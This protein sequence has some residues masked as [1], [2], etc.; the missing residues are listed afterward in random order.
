MGMEFGEITRYIE[1]DIESQRL[2][3][4]ISARKELCFIEGV[5]A[6][7]LSVFINMLHQAEQGNTWVIFPTLEEA[8]NTISDL[9]ALGISHEFFPSTGKSLY[10]TVIDHTINTNEQLN[11]LHTLFKAKNDRQIIVTTVRAFISP[12]I[13]LRAL[14]DNSVALHV[15]QTVDSERLASLLAEAEYERVPKT[16]VPGEFSIRGE[17]IDFFPLEQEHP[18]RLFLDWDSIEKIVFFDPITQ[19]SIETLQNISI[20]IAAKD[21]EGNEYATIEEYI[22]ER[23]TLLCVGYNGMLTSSN[24]VEKEGS[25]EFSKIYTSHNFVRRP[26]DLLLDI[27]S[28]IHERN[29]DICIQDIRGQGQ[30]AVSYNMIGP[31]SYFGNFN[32]FRE[33]IEHL[34]GQGYTIAICAGSRLQKERLEQMLE[35]DAVDILEKTFSS[36]FTIIDKHLVVICEHEIFGRRKKVQKAHVHYKTSPLDSFVDLKPGDLVVH[37]NYGIGRFIQ[38]DRITA[39]GK[40]RDYIKIEYAN[41]DHIFIPIEQANLI[42]RYIGSDGRPPKLD[43]LGGRSWEGRKAR[44]RKSAEDLAKMLIEVYAKRKNSRGYPFSKDTDWQI[45]FEAAFPYEETEDQIQCIQDVKDDMESPA[46]MDR[47]ICGDVGFGKT[48]IAIRAAF[49]AV[50]SGKQVAFLA[51]TTILA[52]QHYE[53]LKER[54]GDFPIRVGMLSRFVEKR[55]QRDVINDLKENK[56][57]I[58]VG[59][60]RI[61]QKDIQFHDLGLLIIDEEQ[62]FGV[63]DKERIKQIKASV[64]SLALSATPIPRTLYMSL[65]KIRDMSLLTTPPFQRRPIKTSIKEFDEELIAQAIR[66]EVSRG[67][68]V[69][70]LHNRVK[71]LDEI[72][73]MLKRIVPEVSVDFAHGQMHSDEIEDKMRRFIHGGFHVLVATTIIEN[74]IDIP[75]VNTII[76][77]RADIYGISQL[78]QLRGR[79]GRSNREAYALLLY[80]SRHVLSEIAMK[81]LKILSEHTELGSGF[82]IAMRDME[83]RG[84]GNLLG[85]E[86]HGQ[87][88]AVGLDMYLRILD[89]AIAEMQH[90][91]SQKEREVYLDLDYSGYIPDEYITDPSVK[92]D[93]YK[94][95]ASISKQEDLLLLEAEMEDRFGRMPEDMVNLLYIAELKIFCKKLSIYHLKE[96]NGI[97]RAEFSKVADIAIENLL[98]LIR[99][100]NG[101]VTIDP[102]RPNVLMLKTDAVSLKDKSLFI[103][104][105][106]QRLL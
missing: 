59:T 71:T 20:Y 84:A 41:Q 69:F 30:V 43:T 79:V 29:R 44:A 7:V 14:D 86:Q 105:K 39:A 66:L 50:M 51:P 85:R 49:K 35:Y 42:Q 17:V 34:I 74:G 40:E 90:A 23:D 12:L 95:I 37:I 28:L 63:K 18:I 64:D 33:E 104:E 76:I 5:E 100:S 62:R 83:I 16:T 25:S 78:Y 32:Y 70:F 47:L 13:R 61:I 60:H 92:F 65:L 73:L 101:Q 98:N 22:H 87:M 99:E 24:A 91:D 103:L 102:K 48:E 106:L 67:G 52:E 19:E 82:K 2:M 72:R 58:L 31:R 54:I 93:I 94:K 10:A 80:P 36:G 68:Q 53:T 81:R 15:G 4:E 75:N 3:R 57:D 11:I 46:V 1:H 88:A 6:P 97:V 8:R 56:L 9:S 21:K 77:D 26:K 27:D 89:E 96:V 38:I 45:Q 55:Q